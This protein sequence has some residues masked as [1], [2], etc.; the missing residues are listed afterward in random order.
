M[1]K[2]VGGNT[3]IGSR[4]LNMLAKTTEGVV[5]SS[6][7]QAH[8]EAMVSSNVFSAINDNYR[9]SNRRLQKFSPVDLKCYGYEL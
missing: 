2:Y 6:A 3:S 5:R 4:A 9:E 8:E 1:A 7:R